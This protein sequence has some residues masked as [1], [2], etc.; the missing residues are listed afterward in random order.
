MRAATA[1]LLA[2]ERRR[3]GGAVRV[4]STRVPFASDGRGRRT[5]CCDARERRTDCSRRRRVFVIE[6][7][8]P[9]TLC[10]LGKHFVT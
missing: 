6:A 8:V 10:A 7:H 4:T 5:A 1:A 2:T 9:G 3:L